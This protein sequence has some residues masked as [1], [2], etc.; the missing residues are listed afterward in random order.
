MFMYLIRSYLKKNYN[1][2]ALFHRFLIWSQI[3]IWQMFDID[4]NVMKRA[5]SIFAIVKA[6][7]RF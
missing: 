5:L 4:M 7:T 2:Y 3:A 1:I 6:F